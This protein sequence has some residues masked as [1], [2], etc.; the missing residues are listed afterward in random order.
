MLFLNNVKLQT[1]AS[2]LPR[3]TNSSCVGNGTLVT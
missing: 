3:E 1:A 2:F